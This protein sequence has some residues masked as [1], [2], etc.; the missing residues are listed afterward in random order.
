[1]SLDRQDKRILEILQADGRITNSELA[2]R[3]NLTPAPT[4]S[5]VNKLES[6]G[7][8]RGYT[9]LIDPLALGLPFLAF[10]SVILRAP[11]PDE[12]ASFLRAMLELP[13]VLECHHV[14]GDED[15]LLKVVATGPRDYESLVMHRIGAIPEVLRVKTMLVLSSGKQTTSLPV[16]MDG[17]Q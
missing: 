13:E 16:P 2:S 3:I 10:V 14:A 11:R 1:V 5:R 12:H 17:D 15:Y 9:A 6:T 8:I 7:V 4:L